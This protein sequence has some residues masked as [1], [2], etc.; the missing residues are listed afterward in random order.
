MLDFSQ[1]F[2]FLTVLAAGP[3]DHFALP[4]GDPARRIGAKGDGA[5]GKAT[6]VVIDPQLKEMVGESCPVNFNTIYAPVASVASDCHVYLAKGTEPLLVSFPHGRGHVVYTSFHNGVQ[7]SDQEKNLLMCI[8]LQTLSL[9]T[10]TPLVE[11]AEATQI[12]AMR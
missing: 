12:N 5:S 11:L 1:R 7:V 4:V 9:A 6:A 2:D 8:I 10:S 3:I